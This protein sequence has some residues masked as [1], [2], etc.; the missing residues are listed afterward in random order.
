MV[1]RLWQGVVLKLPKEKFK[2]EHNFAIK[3]QILKILGEYPRIIKYNKL[4]SLLY[5]YYY[6]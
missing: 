5:L 4:S 2:V 1:F 6:C 3:R